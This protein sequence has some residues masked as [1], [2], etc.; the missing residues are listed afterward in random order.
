M[1][2]IYSLLP[3]LSVL[4]L[5]AFGQRK[6]V[7]NIN[8]QDTIGTIPSTLH[9]IFF[10]EISHAGEGGL[11]AEMIQNRGF[12][13]S[14]IPAGTVLQ[15]GFLVPSPAT[16]HFMLQPRTSDW[17]MEWPYKSDFPAWKLENTGS[18]SAD[19]QLTTE[20]PLHTATPHSLQINITDTGKI[21]LSNE[22]FWGINA[23]AGETYNL[24]FYIRKDARYTGLLT[25]SLQ[26]KQQKILASY[27][28]ETLQEGDWTKYTCQL[29]PT[30]SDPQAKFVLTFGS[31]GTLWLD[32]VS[33]FPAKTFRNRPNG[34]RN[35]IATMIEGLHPSFIRWPGGCFVEG[36]TIESAPNWKNTIGPLEQRPGT[37]SPWGY[38]SSDGFGY[39]EYLQFCE[40]IHADALF[41]FNAGVSCEYRS[42]TFVPDD[43]IAPYIQDALDAIEYATG[44]VTSTWGKARAA[45]G[46]P[47]PFP[48]KYVE[49]GNEQHGPRYAKRYNEFYTAIHKKYPAITIIA[50]M[51]IGDVNRHTLDS[52]HK[53]EMVDEHAYKDA[54]WSL[55]NFDHFDKYKRGNWDMYVGEYATNAGVGAGNMQAALSDAVYILSM[56]KNADL[57]KMSSYAPLLVNENDVD[58]PVNLIHYDASRSFARISYYA[59][60]ML[61]ENKASVNVLSDVA[62]TKE[63]NAPPSFTGGIGLGTWDTQAEYKDIQVTSN[64]K[65]IYQSNFVSK[66]KEWALP[67]GQWKIADSS[68]S[69]TAEG[70]QQLAVLKGH[71]FSTYTLTLKARKTGGI[72]AFMISFGV[73]DN[74]TYKRAHIGSWLN[75]HCVF[76]SVTNG[77]DVAGIS[78]QKRLAPLETGKWYDIRLEV[79]KD[80]VECY[81]DGKLIMTYQEPQQF[82]AITGKAENGD[83]IVKIVNGYGT[84]VPASIQLDASA[85]V[86]PSAQV[87]TLS[88][89]KQE[90]ENSF[91]APTAYTPKT[92]T[93]EGISNQFQWQ[94]PPYSVNIIRLKSGL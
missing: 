58:W 46:H 15:N 8:T 34:L 28:F 27:T 33:L 78:D 75:S 3:F 41:V 52:M 88:A 89:G 76:E 74:N 51:G 1:Y 91:T 84:T 68:L 64:G 72:N 86:Q 9:G 66:S 16:P 36:I 65:V 37:F 77:Y 62:V 22:G 45:N 5:T 11:Y 73:K 94:V 26:T 87:I 60:K 67:R 71:S 39:H 49:V 24:S 50:S 42:G 7:I 80:K 79:G 4:C 59:I 35:D 56:E 55:R 6:A 92:S 70:A 32:F 29:K 40:D 14:R 48:L 21:A 31:R 18:S 90:A 13:E 57:V 25:A 69:Q 81:L 19:I 43:S 53:V 82:Y 85:K 54:Y 20:H 2:K 47:T 12:E 38:W 63:N 10:E 30:A 44:P 83:I 61:A 23:V 17:K 93:L